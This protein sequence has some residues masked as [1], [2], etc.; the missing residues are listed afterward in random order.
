M[1]DFTPVL[2][3]NMPSQTPDQNS[4]GERPSTD[5]SDG[6]ALSQCEPKDAYGAKDGRTIQ[7]SA[8]ASINASCVVDGG[9][10]N[11]PATPPICCVALGK[12]AGLHTSIA[13]TEPCVRPT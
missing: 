1:D 7:S 10:P 4:R 8:P 3:G 11:T 13:I 2:S 6:T 12:S 5:S 9:T